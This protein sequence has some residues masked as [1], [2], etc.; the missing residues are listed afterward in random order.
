MSGKRHHDMNAMALLVLK[1]GKRQ[2]NAATWKNAQVDRKL[3]R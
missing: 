1:T 2:K 3:K